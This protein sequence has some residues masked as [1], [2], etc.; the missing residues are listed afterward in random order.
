VDHLT[1]NGQVAQNDTLDSLAGTL[2][3]LFK[4]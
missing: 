3:G 2:G 4:S 1:P